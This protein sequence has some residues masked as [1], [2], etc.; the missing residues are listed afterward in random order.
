MGAKPVPLVG[1]SASACCLPDEPKSAALLLCLFGSLSV[2]LDVQ[3]LGWPGPALGWAGL[4]GC[5]LDELLSPPLPP[6]Q[7]DGQMHLHR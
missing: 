5:R 2:C 1:P 6:P 3:S 7:R 4:S